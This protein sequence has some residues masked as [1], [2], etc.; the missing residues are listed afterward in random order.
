MGK[1]LNPL[2]KKIL[3]RRYKENPKIKLSDFCTVNGISDT[4]FK[5]WLQQYEEAG[6]EGLARGSM[7]TNILPEGIHTF[8]SEEFEIVDILSRDYSIS[9]LCDLMEVSRAGYYKWKNHEP[10]KIR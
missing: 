8:K 10:T 7:M 2:E 1:Q 6:I 9:M 4:A 3:I 5:K